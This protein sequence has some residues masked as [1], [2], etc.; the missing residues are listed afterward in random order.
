METLV[1]VAQHKD[2]YYTR[3]S[4]MRSVSK[5]G[6]SPCRGFKDIGGQGLESRG[7]LLPNP[8]VVCGSPVLNRALFSPKTPNPVGNGRVNGF[9]KSENGK[10]S[11]K[12][13]SSS[14][15]PINFKVSESEKVVKRNVSFSEC[16][17]GPACFNSPPPSSL[18]IPKFSVKPKRTVSLEL[19]R[20]RSVVDLPPMAKSAPT[21]PTKELANQPIEFLSDDDAA[22]KTLRRILNLDIIDE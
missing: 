22:T 18:P 14:P 1:V 3:R 11:R 2:Q 5:F 10:V 9:C 21:S 15:I 19:P 8:W 13:F 7:G 6:S 20:S 12:G 16:W 17:A 4:K